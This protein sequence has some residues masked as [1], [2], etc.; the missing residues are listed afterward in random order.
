MREEQVIETLKH[1]EVDEGAV[2]ESLLRLAE[3]GK[4]KKVSY[5]EKIFWLPAEEKRGQ[6]TL[7]SRRSYR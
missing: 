3:S 2:Q 6:T 4:I 5:R 7:L 1:V